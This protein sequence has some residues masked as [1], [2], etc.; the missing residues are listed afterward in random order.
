LSYNEKVGPLLD[1]YESKKLLA[2]YGIPITAEFPAA[3]MEEVLKAAGK[4]GYPVVLKTAEPGLV[5]KS[6]VQGIHLNLAN[7]EQVTE[8]Y[9]E[10]AGRLGGQVL[11]QE[12]V[13]GGV[14]LILGLVNDAQFGPLLVIGLG[15]VFVELLENRKLLLLPTTAEAVRRALLKL[16]SARLL[17]GVRGRPAADIE[18]VVEAAL[19]L[20]QMAADFGPRLAEVDINPLV[21]G[22][23]G[24]VAVDALVVFQE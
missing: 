15:G 19:K 21:A 17:H 1:E 8:A 22:P 10:L 6:D 18:A 3:T 5:H 11:V 12:M 2:S 7:P 9:H 14:E 23:E 24:V 4:I 20:A 13:S 16:K